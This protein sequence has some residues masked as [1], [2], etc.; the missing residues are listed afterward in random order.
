[1][2]IAFNWA[3]LVSDTVVQAVKSGLYATLEV[4]AGAT[5]AAAVISLLL[6]ALLFSASAAAR[7]VGRAYVALFR[8]IPLLVLI[9]FLYFGL[10]GLL[11]R[12][13]FPFLYAYQYELVIAIVSVALISAAFI[14]EVMRG[15]IESVAVGQLEAALATGLTRRQGFQHVIL[16]QLG[17]AVLPPLSNEAINIVKN[18]SYTMTI[19]VTE[20]IWQAQQIEA[21]TF[22][23][24]EAMTAV[25]LVFLVLNGA[26]FVA[27]RGLEAL[28]G[29]K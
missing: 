29:R 4:V 15:G 12:A 28:F 14:A 5:L 7:F 26:I 25:T 17:P 13:Q 10:P 22:R 20:L 27:F 11:P 8:N 16:P 19:G 24:F 9:F 21:E 2:A 18:S 23:G 1:M 6:V 3:F